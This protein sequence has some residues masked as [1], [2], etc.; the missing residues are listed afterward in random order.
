MNGTTYIEEASETLMDRIMRERLN[1]L[2]V[3]INERVGNA[4]TPVGEN[5]V[6]RNQEMATLISTPYNN[7]HNPFAA[8]ERN[9][10]AVDT[11]GSSIREWARTTGRT[12]GEETQRLTDILEEER[13]EPVF[14]PRSPILDQ[15]IRGVE[16]G[17]ADNHRDQEI[18]ILKRA[19]EKDRA[20]TEAIKDILEDIQNK[21]KLLLEV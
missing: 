12:T 8:L 1:G 18:E 11:Y 14:T 20:E 10:D 21:L 15:S 6:E 13:R 16:N 4:L 9:S 19:I 3:E 2:S 7:D 17:T 5:Q